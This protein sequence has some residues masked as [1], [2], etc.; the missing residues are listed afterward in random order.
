MSRGSAVV[1]AVS[2]K[3]V[4]RPG[5]PFVK[6]EQSCVSQ[7]CNKP[8]RKYHFWHPYARVLHI[9][10]ATAILRHRRWVVSWLVRVELNTRRA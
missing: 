2:G 7:A 5:R 4:R 3:R 6:S 8:H 1:G 10:V 9:N